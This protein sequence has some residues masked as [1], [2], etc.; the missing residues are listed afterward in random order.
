MNYKTHVSLKIERYRPKDQLSR[1]TQGRTTV[2]RLNEEH[3]KNTHLQ[4]NAGKEEIELE[5]RSEH[6]SASAKL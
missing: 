2:R 1:Q 3:A 6:V 5:E 4:S